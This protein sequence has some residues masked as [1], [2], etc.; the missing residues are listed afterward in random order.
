MF[1]LARITMEIKRFNA[2]S[3]EDQFHYLLNLGSMLTSVLCSTQLLM[4]HFVQ[5]ALCLFFLMLL[6]Y[7]N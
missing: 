4:F 5:E 6:K 2:E 1:D 7:K 3:L